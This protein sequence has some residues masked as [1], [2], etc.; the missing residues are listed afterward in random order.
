MSTGTSPLCFVLT[1]NSAHMSGSQVPPWINTTQNRCKHAGFIYP[2][3]RELGEIENATWNVLCRRNLVRTKRKTRAR[4]E[5]LRNT[6]YPVPRRGSPGSRHDMRAWP[7][8]AAISVRSVRVARWVDTQLV[9]PS[10]D[11]GVGGSVPGA[12]AAQRRSIPVQAIH[13][14]GVLVP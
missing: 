13:V 4:R 6:C 8:H 11:R 14:L 12:M 3:Q 5:R 9:R 2:R 1:L 7:R 10:A